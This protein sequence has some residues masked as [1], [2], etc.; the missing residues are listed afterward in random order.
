MT[1][2]S[3]FFGRLLLWGSLLLSS[4]GAA[5]QTAP[6]TTR[7]RYSEEVL[8]KP[9]P[10]AS[11]GVQREA[12]GLWKLGLNN[13][14]ANQV[15]DHATE[16]D[17]RR[18]GL[19]LAYEHQLGSPTWSVLGE[20]SPALAY[21]KPAINQPTERLLRVRA[22][23]AG[24]YYYNREQ[25]LLRGRRIGSFSSNYLALALGAGLGRRAHETPFFLYFDNGGPLVSTDLALL[26][27]LQ[28]RLGRYGFIDAN[29][30]FASRLGA[31]GGDRFGL[32]L[33]L[34]VGLLL[35]SPLPR[36]ARPAAPAYPPGA[37]PYPMQ[38]VPAYAD[39]SLRPRLYVGVQR[40]F[41]GYRVQYP[42]G[43]PYPPDV[44]QGDPQVE[45][46]VVNYKDSELGQKGYRTYSDYLDTTL[47]YLYAGY[48]LQP[49][50]ALELG[51]LGGTQN[52]GNDTYFR[53]VS[54]RPGQVY[55]SVF[56]LT[57]GRLKQRRL[58][59]PVLLRY[60]LT[61]FFL[62][63]LQV[64]AVGGFTPVWSAAEFREY[65][66]VNHQVTDQQTAGFR[67]TDF[68]VHGS[69]GLDL[70]YGVGRRRRVQ[71]TYQTVYNQDLRTLFKDSNADGGFGFSL[72][73][74]YR[75]AYR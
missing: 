31:E 40:G 47:P 72:G 5:A 39:E 6:D 61:S 14:A 26:W 18:L 75:F 30:G 21:F 59:L 55:D 68:S 41:F 44:R 4:L 17:Y 13:F 38:P 58:A 56:S 7:L 22:Q 51:V 10:D 37:P 65:L 33:S 67:H 16:N 29:A 45:Q 53:K 24:R 52:L 62:R 64:E 57:N 71:L 3:T 19:H 1:N 9:L 63:R 50:L 15:N 11:L 60:S 46:Q 28:R 32:A 54:G 23:L 43:Y 27:G 42:D 74:R 66:I 48:Y 25:R 73:L 70:A 35:G 49:R 8:T 36:P 34:R 12:A 69:L 2:A 20:V